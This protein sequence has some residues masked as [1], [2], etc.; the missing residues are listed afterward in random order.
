MPGSVLLSHAKLHTI[1]GAVWFHFRVRDGIEWVTYAIA[2]KQKLV[3]R[4]EYL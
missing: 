3:L 4:L 2:T 1:I